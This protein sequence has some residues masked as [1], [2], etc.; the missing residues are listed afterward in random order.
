VALVSVTFA[1]TI[2][3]PDWSVTAPVIPPV[4]T[5]CAAAKKGSNNASSATIQSGCL[6]RIFLSSFCV[7]LEMVG[8][9][10]RTAE[11]RQL[12]QIRNCPHP[13]NARELPS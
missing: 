6:N 2:T 11:L 4:T 5:L 13:P 9:E 1:P 3:A 8:A 10:I 7:T 12:R